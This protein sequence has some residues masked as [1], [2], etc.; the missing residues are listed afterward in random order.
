[1]SYEDALAMEGRVSRLHLRS[2]SNSQTVVD[3]KR[4]LGKESLTVPGVEEGDDNGEIKP[5]VKPETRKPRGENTM[6]NPPATVSPGG[7]QVKL[8]GFFETMPPAF[9]KIVKPSV[10][11]FSGDPLEYGEV[12]SSI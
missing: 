12:Q 9:T 3:D 7:P 2:A 10:P 4:S 6:C 5:N 11:K 1:M 8:D